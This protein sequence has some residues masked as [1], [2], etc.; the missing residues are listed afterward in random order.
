VRTLERHR[1]L[2]GML[3]VGRPRS[4]KGL[5]AITQLLGA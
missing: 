4:G 2:G 5:L 1:E 3:I